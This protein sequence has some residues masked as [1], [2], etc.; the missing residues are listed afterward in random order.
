M[1]R[2][3]F[4][5]SLLGLPLLGQKRTKE[6]PGTLKYQDKATSFDEWPIGWKEGKALN[7]QCPVCGTMVAAWRP[8]ADAGV[9]CQWEVNDAGGTSYEM[10][11]CSPPTERRIDCE[12]CNATFRQFA[13]DR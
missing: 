9:V 5:A 6:I 1:K 4:L 13:E 12:R 8:K 7:N 11:P 10:K 2:L 3:T